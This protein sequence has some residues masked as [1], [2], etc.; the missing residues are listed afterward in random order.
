VSRVTRRR[1][2]GVLRVLCRKETLLTPQIVVFEIRCSGAS[3]GLGGCF[4][5][6]NGLQALQDQLVIGR[7]RF[8]LGTG[9][10]GR[11]QKASNRIPTRRRRYNHPRRNHPCRLHQQRS[12]AATTACDACNRAHS[13]SSQQR[14]KKGVVRKP[15]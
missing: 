2:R 5:K 14:A 4:L 3:S 12:A 6:V 9:W 7:L 15:F 1:E 10:G 13:S 8:F 11:D